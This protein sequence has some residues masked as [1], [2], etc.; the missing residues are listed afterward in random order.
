MGGSAGRHFV[1]S[2]AERCE[3]CRFWDRLRDGNERGRGVFDDGNYT[4][5]GEDTGRCRRRAPS[6]SRTDL[7]LG[8]DN[9]DAAQ[10]AYWP[11]TWSE[12]WCG[13]YEAAVRLVE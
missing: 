13:D 11:V 12:D 2:P 9:A 4:V 7:P 3:R 6:T 1:S 10:A 8:T 5:S